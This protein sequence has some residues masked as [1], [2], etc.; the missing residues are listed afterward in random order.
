MSNGG[1]KSLFYN[2]AEIDHSKKTKLKQHNWVQRENK[3]FHDPER[4]IKTSK[5]KQGKAMA[6][7]ASGLE[8]QPWPG[9]Q[10]LQNNGDQMCST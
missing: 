3:N 6:F 2:T 1:G 7:R 8:A 9:G 10:F 4:K 5:S